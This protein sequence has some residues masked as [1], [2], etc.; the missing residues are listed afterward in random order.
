MSQYLEPSYL[1]Y[2]YDQLSTQQLSS[3]NA[4][5]LPDG[6]IGLYEQYF[7]EKTTAS[8][9]QD[10]LIQLA[11]FA[12]MDFLVLPKLRQLLRSRRQGREL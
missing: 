10:I 2:V 9:R 1:R 6:F 7:L 3:D 5:A 11:T 12:L 4:A 8:T